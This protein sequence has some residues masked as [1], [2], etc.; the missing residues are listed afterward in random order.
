MLYSHNKKYPKL[1]PNRIRLSN[2]LTKTENFSQEEL[3]SAGY[4]LAPEMPTVKS[5]QKIEWNEDHW[6]VLDKSKTDI[7][8]QWNNI[9][10]MRD[11]KIKEI[12]WKYNR[13]YRHERL[14]LTQIDSI[15]NLDLYVQ[16][17]ADITKQENPFNIIWPSLT[18]NNNG[19]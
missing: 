16:A 13:Y 7:E 5:L 18:D 9:R 10:N 6:V 11:E 15:Q 2:G 17:L 14:G 8:K 3:T 19:T 12:E 4:K 1:L